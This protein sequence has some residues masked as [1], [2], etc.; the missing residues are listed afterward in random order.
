MQQ[1]LRSECP[2]CTRGTPPALGP[3]LGTLLGLPITASCLLQA[4]FSLFCVVD[5]GSGA[6]H[7]L[8]AVSL[9]SQVNSQPGQT[10]AVHLLSCLPLSAEGAEGA[11]DGQCRTSTGRWLQG[12][13]TVLE[14][15]NVI[16]RISLHYDIFLMLSLEG[17]LQIMKRYLMVVFWEDDTSWRKSE[18]SW[19]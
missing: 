11:E 5:S 3:E 16:S 2:P 15:S 17:C 18:N 13:V 10:R 19:G 8:L 1:T 6:C 7:Q 9:R 14:I 4:F 12:A